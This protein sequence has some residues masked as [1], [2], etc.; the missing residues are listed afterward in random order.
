ME[1]DNGSSDARWV[2]HAPPQGTHAQQT[3]ANIHESP[4]T[5][6][7]VQDSCKFAADAVSSLGDIPNCV[8]TEFASSQANR[9]RKRTERADTSVCPYTGQA[10]ANADRAAV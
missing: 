2:L 10:A 1:L 8:R 9:I 5:R 7:S 6:K 4:R 3:A